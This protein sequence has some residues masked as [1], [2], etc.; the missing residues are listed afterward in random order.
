M[1][2][3]S[4]FLNIIY[5]VDMCTFKAQYAEIWVWASENYFQEYGIFFYTKSPRDQIQ[6]WDLVARATTWWA[7]LLASC[8]EFQ[9]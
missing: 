8:L 7:I 6:F 3:R 5:C 2:L 1:H 4:Q 9:C